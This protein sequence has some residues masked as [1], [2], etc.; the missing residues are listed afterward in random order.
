MAELQK[1][2]HHELSDEELKRLVAESDTGGRKPAARRRSSPPS[3]SR[4]RCSSSGSPRRCPSRSA[5]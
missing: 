3:P 2:Q 5:S 4:G 1:P